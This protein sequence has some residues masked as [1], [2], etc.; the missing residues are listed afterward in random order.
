[1]GEKGFTVLELIVAMGIFLLIIPPVIVTLGQAQ[2]MLTQNR[3]HREALSLATEA[4]QTLQA[5]S[6]TDFNSIKSSTVHG[7]F[8]QTTVNVKQLNLF[9]KEVE[10][11][12][13][14]PTNSPTIL[15]VKLHTLVTDPQ[16]ARNADACLAVPKTGTAEVI[17]ELEF[18]PDNEPTGITVRNNLV[19]VT[20]NSPVQEDSDFFVVDA[21]QP[22]NPTIVAELDTGPGLSGL[23]IS[24]NH[25]YAGNTSINGQLQIINLARPTRP[26]LLTTYKLPGNYTDNTTIPNVVTY[27]NNKVYLGTAKSQI[28][29]FHVIDVSNRSVPN[30]LGTFEF[31]AGINTIIVRNNTAYVVSPVDEELKIID[32]TNPAQLRQI[33]GFNAPGGSGNGKSLDVIEQ[34]VFFGR[35]LGGTEL[36]ILDATN[37]GTIRDLASNDINTSV[38]DLA[39]VPNWLYL[40]TTDPGKTLQIRTSNLTLHKSLALNAKATN[41]ACNKDKLYAT[42]ENTLFIIKP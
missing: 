33:G 35:T 36:Y 4:I 10:V 25:A 17:G 38:N 2:T 1:M 7:A 42:A 32:I 13:S 41:L 20:T 40:A 16:S 19:F 28:R 37:P 5:Q 39:A 26:T 3:N 24:E 8:F 22:D 12:I 21:R 18:G 9:A 29:E 14:W 15:P 34:Q 31:S 23:A 6:I 30:E 27:Q 11:S